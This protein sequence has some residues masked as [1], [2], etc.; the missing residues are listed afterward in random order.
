LLQD[1]SPIPDD[2]KS[3]YEQHKAKRTRP[4]IEDISKVLQSVAAGYSRTFIVI[5]ALDECQVSDGARGRFLS[6]IFKF[7]AKTGAS[8]FVTSRFIPEI[9]KEFE[10]SISLEIR[11]SDEDVLRYIDG[12]MPL[13][14]RSHISRYPDLQ[15]MVRNDVLKAVDG[16]CGS[17]PLN[18]LYSLIDVQA[19]VSTR[20]TTHGLPFEQTYTRGS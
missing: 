15:N 8:L 9:R 2:L 12:R 18:I 11:A 19:Q 4:S 20:A 10:G 7:Q 1:I 17:P 6:E 13:L 16:M 5:D 3:L 14:L